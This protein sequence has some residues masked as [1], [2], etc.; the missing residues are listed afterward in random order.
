MGFL[1][2]DGKL[3]PDR[4]QMVDIEEAAIIDLIGGHPPEGR[5][6]GL[7]AEQFVQQ[8]EAAGVSHGAVEG[9]HRLFNAARTSGLSGK[10]Q[11]YGV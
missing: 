5:P 6:V 3:H 8:V 7:G 10:G 11:Q 2:D 1:K 4:R 9:P